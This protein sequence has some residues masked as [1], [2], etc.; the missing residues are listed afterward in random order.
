MNNPRDLS[1]LALALLSFHYERSMQFLQMGSV[2]TSPKS[3]SPLCLEKFN[4]E[5]TEGLCVLCVTLFLPQ[6][7]RSKSA[8]IPPLCLERR[9]IKVL[10]RGTHRGVTREGAGRD[11]FGHLLLYITKSVKW[12]ARHAVLSAIG[13]QLLLGKHDVSNLHRKTV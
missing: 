2:R 4:T 1:F 12:P 6:R 9:P 7:T 11:H 13:Q 3:L 8:A 10:R 5:I